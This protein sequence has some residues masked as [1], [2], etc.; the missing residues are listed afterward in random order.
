MALVRLQDVAKRFG[1]TEVLRGISFEVADHEKVVICGRSGSGKSTLLRCINGLEHHDAGRIE[2]GGIEVTANRRVLE[3]VRRRVG[4]VFQGFNLFPHLTVLDNC[5]LAPT[6]VRGLPVADARLEALNLLERVHLASLAHRY[7]S[8]LSGGEQQRVA[9][10]RALCMNPQVMLFD[11]PTSSLDPVM[12]QEVLDVIAELADA[13]MTTI[14]VTHEMNFARRLADRV[15]FLDSGRI[16]E[17]GPPSQLFTQ[18]RSARLKA[19]LQQERPGAG[20]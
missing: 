9:I 3:G 13:G 19:F 12:V 6:D 5:T 20:G 7:P 17:V 18:P 15:I 16:E 11:E 10:A 1:D 14:C 8:E 4:M 2:V